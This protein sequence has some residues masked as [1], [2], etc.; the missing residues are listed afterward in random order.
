MRI[1]IQRYDRIK[2]LLPMSYNV[3]NIDIDKLSEVRR[4]LQEDQRKTNQDLDFIRLLAN[5]ILEQEA[6]NNHLLLAKMYLST[7]FECQSLQ[8]VLSV[9]KQESLRREIQDLENLVFLVLKMLVLRLLR[10]V[11]MIDSKPV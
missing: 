9:E 7:L 2:R 6:T 3:E 4:K 1:K 10:S 8:E 11:K 5:T